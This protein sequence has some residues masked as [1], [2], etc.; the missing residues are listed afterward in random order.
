MKIRRIGSVALAAA[1]SLGTALTGYAEETEAVEVKEIHVGTTGIVKPFSFYDE[2]NQLTGHDVEMIEAIFDILPQYELAWDI[3]EHDSIFS[4]LDA[5]RIQI[6]AN[7]YGKNDERKEKY[8]FSLPYL[9]SINLVITNP[10]IELK[11][12]KI[13]LSDLS[14]YTYAGVA[15]I[16]TTALV[17]DYNEENPD[18]QINIQYV[19]ND[20]QAL[21]SNVA[22]GR[23][24][25]AILNSAIYYGYYQ[26]ELG[27]DL[28]AA[29]LD[30]ENAASYVYLLFA[31]GNDQLVA[32]VD[33]ALQELEDNGTL[34]ELSEKYF[35]DD[36]TPYDGE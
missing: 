13:S 18:A 24:D 10:D 12:D 31:K 5:D 3:G 17:E 35:G 20:T 7:N 29:E 15:G 19:E 30:V 11:G 27:Y 32:D 9:Y 16:N 23:Y 6:G 8:D 26:P 21:L 22:D 36:F 2:E 25:F 34:K 4:G 28:N 33:G 1:L 14:D